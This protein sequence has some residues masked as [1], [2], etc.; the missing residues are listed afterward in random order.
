MC[1]CFFLINIRLGRY[2]MRVLKGM[3][4]DYYIFPLM[5]TIQYYTRGEGEG[6]F[7]LLSRVR[8]YGFHIVTF[9]TV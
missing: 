9:V 8:N 5:I 6:F 7:F 1:N 3:M 2:T 4:D